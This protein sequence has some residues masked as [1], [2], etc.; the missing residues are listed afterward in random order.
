MLVSLDT[1]GQKSVNHIQRCTYKYLNAGPG[2][3]AGLFIHQK[4]GS[5]T[6]LNRYK[7]CLHR[8]IQTEASLDL[9]AGGEPRMKRDSK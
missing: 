6:S 4:H 3:I 7:E 1:N 8:Y 9:Q 5:N 2:S